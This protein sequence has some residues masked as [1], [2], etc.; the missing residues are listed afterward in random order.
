MQK[1][2]DSKIIMEPCKIENTN[3]NIP[4][5][6]ELVWVQIHKIYDHVYSR[7]CE[8]KIVHLKGC[9]MSSCSKFTFEGISKYEII[10]IIIVSSVDIFKKPGFKKMCLA[11]VI[12]FDMKYS[13]GENHFTQT[14]ELTFNIGIQEIYCPLSCNHV[15]RYSKKCLQEHGESLSMDG[16]M[17]DVEAVPEIINDCLDYNDGKLCLEIGVF[18]IVNTLNIVRLLIPS[19]GH[20]SILNEQYNPYALEDSEFL[21]KKKYPFPSQIYPESRKMPSIKPSNNTS[22]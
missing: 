4:S 17:I 1:D 20:Y 21:N 22:W 6:T 12:K 8:K 13:N 2:Y 10:D 18:F 9:P 11:V 14:E 16:I 5:P 15:I 7:S 3:C 19:Y